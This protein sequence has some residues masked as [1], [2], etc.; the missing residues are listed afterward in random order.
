[1]KIIFPAI[2]ACLTLL[3]MDCSRSTPQLDTDALRAALQNADAAWARTAGKG[4]ADAFTSFVAEDG[5]ILPPN[6]AILSDKNAIKNWVAQ[7]MAVPGYALD[8]QVTSADVSKSGE[9]GYTVGTYELSVNDANGK[10][11]P[12]MGKYVTVW[13]MQDGEWKV[14]ADIFNSD[15][16]LE[17]PAMEQ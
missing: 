2:L 17:A 14:V 4:D 7:L 11:I 5:S 3:M 1:M 8:W 13:R 16:P 6:V 10:P 12:D 9:L 15:L